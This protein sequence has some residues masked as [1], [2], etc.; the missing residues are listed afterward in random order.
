MARTRACAAQVGHLGDQRLGVGVVG[1]GKDFGGGRNLHDLPRYMMATRSEMA[2]HAQVVADEQVGQ[3]RAG[4]AGPHEQ[5]DDLRL[6]R[7]IQRGHGLSHTRNLGSTISA[8]AMPTR[9]RCPPE[10]QASRSRYSGPGPLRPGPVDAGRYPLAGPALVHMQR[11]AQDLNCSRR[12]GLERRPV[13]PGTPSAR[14]ACRPAF[15]GNGSGPPR[16]RP[17]TAARLRWVVQV[18]TMRPSVDL[19]QPDL[20]TRASTSPCA[21]DSSRR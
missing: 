3:G 20:P 19:P 4:P 17:G 13:G 6:D 16:W 9:W 8:R 12:R 18:A 11:L 10:S 15:I 21:M 1:A 2:H 14:P 5:V 7:H